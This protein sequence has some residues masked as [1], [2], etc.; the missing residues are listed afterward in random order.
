[1]TLLV[2]GGSGSGKSAWAERVIAKVP[3]EKR[4][5][6]ATMQASDGESEA[7]VRLHRCQRASLGF[8]TIECP[9]DIGSLCL[10]LGCAALLEDVPNLLANEMFGGDWERIMPGI[11]KLARQCGLLV[12]VTGNVFCDGIRYDAATQDY[13][14][15]LAQINS[16]LAAL[17]DAVTEVV[18]SIPVALK[19][20]LPCD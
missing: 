3:Q 18:Y 1:M 15:R 2:I 13:I 17:A 7:R 11:E 20:A 5:Y 8:E 4:Y 12:L 16:A 10:P 14:Q 19:G 9:R 6:I